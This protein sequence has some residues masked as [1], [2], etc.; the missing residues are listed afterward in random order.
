MPALSAREGP[1]LSAR[2]G[3]IG[4][5]FRPLDYLNGNCGDAFIFVYSAGYGEAEFSI[6]IDSNV[7]VALVHWNVNW[8]NDRTGGSN[9]VYGNSS[10]SNAYYW[11]KLLIYCTDWGTVHAHFYGYTDNLFGGTCTIGQGLE[12]QDHGFVSPSASPAP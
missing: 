8:Q 3:L 11:S 1:P 12:P 5:N 7:A 6:G 2:G 4:E 10:P 9:T